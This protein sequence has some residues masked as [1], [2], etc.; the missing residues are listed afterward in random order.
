MSL[1]NDD[2]KMISRGLEPQFRSIRHEMRTIEHRTNKKFAFH[3]TLIHKLQVEIANIRREMKENG[4]NLRKSLSR[5]IKD[6]YKL[7]SQNHPTHEEVDAKIESLRDD[8]KA[9]IALVQDK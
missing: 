7:F 2:I 9:G 4:M 5:M 3:S 1:T 8:I 6:S